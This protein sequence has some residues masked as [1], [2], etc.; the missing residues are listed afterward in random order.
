MQKVANVVKIDTV[1]GFKA[2]AL[3]EECTKMIDEGGNII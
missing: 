1:A 3:G 2:L